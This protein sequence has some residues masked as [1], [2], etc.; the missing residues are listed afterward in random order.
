M[1]TF[2]KLTRVLQKCPVWVNLDRVGMIER[3]P[4]VDNEYAGRAPERTEL[5]FRGYG[6][7]R[8]SVAVVET[9]EQILAQG[10]PENAC[11]DPGLCVYVSQYLARGPADLTHA[12]FHAAEAAG[13][14]H[15]RN[16][17]FTE[18]THRFCEI[19]IDHERRVRV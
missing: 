8:E 18:R 17:T 2:V 14:N 5:W 12:G 15:I 11:P 9:P 4:A 13:A 16:C 7:D 3:L 10:D 19:C 6:D 1:P